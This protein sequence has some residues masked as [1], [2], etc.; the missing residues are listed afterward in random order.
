MAAAGIRDRF[1]SA[2]RNIDASCRSLT[3][4]GDSD[5]FRYYNPELEV[6]K[7][8]KTTVEGSV[9]LVSGRSTIRL[10]VTS[11]IITD[12]LNI[13]FEFRNPM[14]NL[15]HSRGG[16]MSN[17]LRFKGDD[18][19][20]AIGSMNQGVEEVAIPPPDDYKIQSDVEAAA[21]TAAILPL[22]ADLAQADVN[23]VHFTTRGLNGGGDDRTNDL[24]AAYDIEATEIADAVNQDRAVDRAVVAKAN[25]DTAAIGA[26]V[27]DG[28]EA[29]HFIHVGAVAGWR[30]LAPYNVAVMKPDQLIERILVYIDGVNVLTMPN[31]ESGMDFKTWKLMMDLIYGCDVAPTPLDWVDF[32]YDEDPDLYRFMNKAMLTAHK[33]NPMRTRFRPELNADGDIVPEADRRWSVGDVHYSFPLGWYLVKAGVPDMYLVGSREMQIIVLFHQGVDRLASLKQTS[34]VN[35]ALPANNNAV[36]GTDPLAITDRV[37][38]GDTMFY[39]YQVNDDEGRAICRHSII[40]KC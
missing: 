2:V 24:K 30:E 8:S 16:R 38:L 17:Y 11:P 25:V 39:S 27:D 31:P 14:V 18:R 1:D 19:V 20:Y 26:Y 10:Q 13:A 22:A 12:S 7:F 33:H 37:E 6:A 9:P 35:R 21:L 4:S 15:S 23:R 5:V 32:N 29:G 36:Y 34:I 3:Q 28:L 40:A